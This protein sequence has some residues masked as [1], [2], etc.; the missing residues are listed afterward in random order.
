LLVYYAAVAVLLVGVASRRVRR[1]A[2]LVAT[3]MI[4]TIVTGPVALLSRPAPGTLRVTMLDV[5]QGEA[6]VVQLPA[7]HVLVVDGGAAGDGFDMGER[8]VTPA[9]WALGARTVDWV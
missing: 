1:A 6:I 3:V 5:G 9:L 7:G 2:R 8:V 4:L